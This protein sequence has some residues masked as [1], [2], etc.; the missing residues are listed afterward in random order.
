MS[1]VIREKP[2]KLLWLE[3][4]LRR[5]HERDPELNYYTEQFRRL[6]AGFAG[7]QRVDREW[8]EII[9]PNTFLFCI[10]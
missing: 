9:C 8:H 10:I 5:L 3:A 6:Y 2:L 1:L 7:E 4:L